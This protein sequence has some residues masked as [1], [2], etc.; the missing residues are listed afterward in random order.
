MDTLQAAIPILAVY[1]KE[2]AVLGKYQH[3]WTLGEKN[4]NETVT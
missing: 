3:G 1:L 2:M 4:M